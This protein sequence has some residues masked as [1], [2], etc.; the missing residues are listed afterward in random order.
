MSNWI[1]TSSALII[2][3]LL[4]RK[5]FGE[6]LVPGLQYGLWLLV[7][8]RLSIPVSFWNS[9]YSLPALADKV[10]EWTKETETEE[11][12]I[13]TEDSAS[14][15]A[16]YIKVIPTD[17]GMTADYTDATDER[18]YGAERSYF[19]NFTYFYV[20]WIIGMAVTGGVFLLSNLF[21]RIRIYSDREEVDEELE[22]RE[23]FSK[24]PVYVSKFV[25]TPC[26]AGL[27]TPAVYIP[28]Q[29]WRENT[30]SGSGSEKNNRE[31][32][33]M[34]CHENVHYRHG[35]QLWSFLRLLCLIIHWY[36]PLAWAAALASKQDAELFCDAGT[37]R[38]LGEEN[39]YEYGRTLLKMTTKEG[40][41][42]ELSDVLR[43]AGFCNTEMAD[44][45]KHME[46]RIRKLAAMPDKRAVAVA[47]STLLLGLTAFAYL[48]TGRTE[49]DSLFR[50][51]LTG[52]ETEQGEVIITQSASQ[53]EESEE[54]F[55][56]LEEEVEEVRKTALTGMDEEEIDRLTTY[57]KDYH[58][59]LE[60]RLLYDNWERK[61]SDQNN[62]A[63]NFIDRTGVVQAGFRLEEDPDSFVR[64][65][66]EELNYLQE[67]YP[68]Y[69]TVSLEELREKY[70]EPYYEES[71]YG[72]ET[73]IQRIKE[74]TASAENE[75]FRSDVEKFCSTLQQAKDTHEVS[76]VMQAHEILHDM[77]Y[78]LLRYSPRDVAPFT[79]DKS[80]SGKYYGALEV[81]KAWREGQL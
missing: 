26:L 78:F 16:E 13:Y 8:V 24:V 66:E 65:E 42:G 38:E 21:F 59:W 17:A 30:E 27:R 6:K 34:L 36:N 80:L 64:V 58:N 73:V 39:R 12:G 53:D 56:P 57:V 5:L 77:E 72:A 41:F 10:I 3:I 31:L 19:G 50:K 25:T 33:T 81:W 7:V 1:L 44:T 18:E 76:Y 70:G 62:V 29:I 37:V 28:L 74:L 43:H 54:T 48:F 20:V 23:L 4:I 75:T 45:K 22:K 15:D 11:D 52:N 55:Y 61:L 69:G 68:E 14:E 49:Q 67:K 2:V 40:H 46:R 47:M 71:R 35:D 60:A 51:I 79:Q 32:K 63:W 9:S